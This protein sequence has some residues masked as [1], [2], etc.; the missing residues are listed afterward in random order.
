MFNRTGRMA[1]ALGAL[2]MVCG[3]TSAGV[4]ELVQETQKSTTVDGQVSMVWWMPQEFWDESLKASGAAVPE[5]MRTQ[6]LTLMANYNIIAVLRGRT[7]ALGLTD[8]QPKAEM[9]KNISLES[10]G[11]VI[12]PLAPE[13]LDPGAQV[14]LAQLKPGLAATIGQMGQAMEFLVYPGQAE[15]SRLIDPVKAGELKVV[16]YG[17]THRIRLPLGSLMP[18][19]VDGKTGEQFPGNYQFN[20]FTGDKLTTR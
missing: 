13:Q 5:E 16:F 15:G 7:G 20:P 6:I 2:W 19:R 1:I 12:A 3:A 14:L 18:L 4:Q 8:V 10:G 11:K 17:Q 9:Q